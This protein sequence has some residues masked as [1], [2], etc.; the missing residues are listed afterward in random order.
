MKRF[1]QQQSST[2]THNNEAAPPIKRKIQ[3][4]FLCVMSGSEMAS[5]TPENYINRF[6]Y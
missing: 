2:S 3:P 4:V 5:S 1:Q 6:F